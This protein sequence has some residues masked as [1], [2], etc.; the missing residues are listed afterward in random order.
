MHV[1]IVR[2][3]TTQPGKT[4]VVTGAVHGNEQC[5]TRAIQRLINDLDA[6]QI[7][8]SQGKLLLIPICNPRAFDAKV[9]FIERNLNRYLYPKTH[10]RYYEDHLDPIICEVLRQADVLLDLHSYAS[11]GGPFVFLGCQNAEELVFARS[12]GVHNFIYGWADAF[13]ANKS[14][15]ADDRESMGT[16]EYARSKGA[17]AATLECGN[18]DNEDADKIGY[19]GIL[20][21]LKHLDMLSS[22]S[23]IKPDS[24]IESTVKALPTCCL[25]MKYVFYKE[26]EGEFTQ[27]WRHFDAV[28]KGQVLAQLADGHT[29]IAPE[30]GYIVLPKYNPQIGGE[31]FYMGIETQFPH[32]EMV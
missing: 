8:L 12:L 5:G 10:C 27:P 13:S 1:K 15:S 7:T 23:A 28:E 17:I 19:Q 31:W 16:T 3:E 21:A 18:H 22:H 29:I 4:L 11:P 26:Q 2:Y 20:N 6:G 32:H 24:A 14:S 9:R 25:K 30:D